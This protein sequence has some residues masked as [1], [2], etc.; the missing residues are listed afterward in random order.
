MKKRI[1]CLC[2][3]IV[4]TFGGAMV[5]FAA[6]WTQGA[7]GRYWYEKNDG[8]YYRN[9]MY[10]IDGA[11]YAFD[12]EGYMLTG[13]QNIS[14][15]WYYFDASGAAH[16][17]W[18][19]DNGNWYYIDPSSGEMKTHWLDLGKNRY[20]LNDKGV[21]QTGL[22]HISKSLPNSE[23]YYQAD[24]NGVLIRNKYETMGTQTIFHNSDGCMYFKNTE[25]TLAGKISDDTQWG[26]MTD[27][28]DIAEQENAHA[29]IIEERKE[30]VMAE[31]VESYTKSV[32]GKTAKKRNKEIQE[33]E[34]RAQ[35]RL[36]K[37]ATPEEISSFIYSVTSGT[38]QYRY[39]LIDQEGN[40]LDYTDDEEEAEDWFDYD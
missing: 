20:Y 35:K 25:S 10:T 12:A 39:I 38:G 26:M 1:V 18:L 8:S 31:L 11:R 3:A 27:D 28:F 2:T 16:N 29:E 17:G 9:G 5:S 32:T 4:L 37:Y 33:W 34:R 30:E 24:G 22:F 19:Q 23:F 14:G 7:D 6:G 21:M 40:L 15:K 13:W 36:E